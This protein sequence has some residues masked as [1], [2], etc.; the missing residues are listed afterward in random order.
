MFILHTSI[1]LYWLTEALLLKFF[2]F[3]TLVKI[4]KTISRATNWQWGDLSSPKRHPAFG[5]SHLTRLCSFSNSDW[6]WHPRNVAANWGTTWYRRTP[7]A[8][9]G[10]Q[11]KLDGVESFLPHL[12]WQYMVGQGYS[13]FFIPLLR[14]ATSFDHL[15]RTTCLPGKHQNRRR[16]T[17]A[18]LCVCWRFS[19]TPFLLWKCVFLFFYPQLW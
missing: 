4:H 3:F 17:L 5:H 8:S 6:W 18:W 7:S 10:F 2:W 19:L 12:M 15:A 1:V 13:S 11:W 9:L 16:T 14:P